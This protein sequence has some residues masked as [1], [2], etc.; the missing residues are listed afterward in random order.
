[1][2]LIIS[3]EHAD[4]AVPA[5]WNYLFPSESQSVRQSHR[6]W[7]PGARE[8]S[9]ALARNLS[10]PVLEGKVTRLLIDLN[11]SPDNP[12]RWSEF[13]KDLT[14]EVKDRIHRTVFQ[15]YWDDL[16]LRIENGI[17]AEE[18]VLHL[19]V[20]SFIR[21][22]NGEKRT[23]DLGL[24][25]D[26]ARTGETKT[27]SAME[28]SLRKGPAARFR[29]RHNEPYAGIDDGLTTMLRRLYPD[30]KY[31]G[32]EIEVCSDLLEN[33]RDREDLQNAVIDAV[34]SVME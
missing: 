22:L 15:P 8:L 4:H 31:Q 1:M 5:P 9:R 19:S 34:R 26:P 11:R 7:D 33:A 17:Q 2:Q 14:S 28:K 21:E 10:I 32:I 16:K 3:C 24:L 29:I 18:C 25:F 23:V 12:G 30:N 20:H 13:T 27:V 6:G